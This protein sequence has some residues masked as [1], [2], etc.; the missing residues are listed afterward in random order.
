M[1]KMEKTNEIKV[2]SKVRFC[3]A[4]KDVV[5]DVRRLCERGIAEVAVKKIH[6]R[7][8]V[9]TSKIYR[10]YLTRLDLVK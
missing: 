6:G 3:V 1:T 4:G 9:E 7:S 8:G 5:G 10:P 2:G